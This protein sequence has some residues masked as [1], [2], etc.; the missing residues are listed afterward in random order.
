[1]ILSLCS[2]R[3]SHTRL[4]PYLELSTM[5]YRLPKLTGNSQFSL[6]ITQ[7]HR[8]LEWTLPF[9]PCLY[10]LA[11]LQLSSLQALEVM[12]IT[13]I[14]LLSNLQAGNESQ[15]LPNYL[16]ISRKDRLFTSPTLTT[17]QQKRG[18][19]V[20]LLFLCKFFSP[21]LSE[22]SFKISSMIEDPRKPLQTVSQQ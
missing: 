17:T 20:N 1:M 19:N 9:S 22:V 8:K 6:Y 18:N 12:R 15:H 11:I 4:D 5:V 14:L 21:A 3:I 16:Q 13:G 10:F 2:T 7:S